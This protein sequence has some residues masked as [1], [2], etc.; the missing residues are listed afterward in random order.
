MHDKLMDAGA[1]LLVRTI[2]G[3]A[4]NS[5]EEIPQLSVAEGDLKSAPKLFKETMQIN[6]GKPANEI[7]NFIRGL[8]PYPAAHTILAGKQLKVYKAHAKEETHGVDHGT[9]QTDNSTYLRFATTDGW[10]YIEEL[11]LEGKKRMNIAD[12]LRGFRA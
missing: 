6:W 9:Y 5:L 2:K 7:N 4:E 12:F 3:L 10:V 11:Q 8:S 1:Q